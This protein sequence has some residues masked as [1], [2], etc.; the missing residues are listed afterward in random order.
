MNE[1]ETL[2]NRYQRFAALPWNC[3]LAGPQKVWFAVYSPRQERRVRSRLGDFQN[4]TIS[5]G[6]SWLLVDLTDAFAEWMAR[7]EYRAAYFG[8]P[9]LM[10][11]ALADFEDDLVDRVKLVLNDPSVDDNAVVAVLGLASLFGLVRASELIERV[12]PYI[13]GRLLGFFPGQYDGATWRLL[14]ARDG[15][16]YHAVPITGVPEGG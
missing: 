7:H 1:I 12:A 5:A 8:Q 14:D 9:E 15:W 16:N 11:M 13:R 6:H 4:A 2:L 3:N 10:G